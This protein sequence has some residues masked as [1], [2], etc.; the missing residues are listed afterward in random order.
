MS[1]IDWAASIKEARTQRDKQRAGRAA[2]I[3]MRE[4]AKTDPVGALSA[5]PFCG[6]NQRNTNAPLAFRGRSIEP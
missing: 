1:K 5:N 4:R 3:A 2:V 6:T